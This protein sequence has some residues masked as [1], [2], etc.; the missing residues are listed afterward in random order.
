MFAAFK[1]A[2]DFSDSTHR[3]IA[4]DAVKFTIRGAAYGPRR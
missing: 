3:R 2:N 4:A 1:N